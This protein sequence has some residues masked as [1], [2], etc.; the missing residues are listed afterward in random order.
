VRLILGLVILVGL[1]ALLVRLLPSS[2]G[3]P[4]YVLF[5]IV[6]ILFVVRERRAIAERRKRL[7]RELRQSRVER[8]MELRDREQGADEA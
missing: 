8:D 6:T 7:E 3:L 1:F 4:L 2:W 5:L